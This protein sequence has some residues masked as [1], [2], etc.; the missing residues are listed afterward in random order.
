VQ[1]PTAS[2]RRRA[3]E[4][5]ARDRAL[6]SDFPFSVF[7]F[8][9]IIFPALPAFSPFWPPDRFAVSVSISISLALHLTQPL[10]LKTPRI[11]LNLI[12]FGFVFSIVALHLIFLFVWFFAL[13]A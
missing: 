13:I 5:A 1:L 10:K 11:D 8:Q 9:F 7:H 4:H 6:H 2:S 3:I 12:V